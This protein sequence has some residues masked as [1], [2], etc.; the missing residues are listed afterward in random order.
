MALSQAQSEAGYATPAAMVLS[1]AIAITALA[2]LSRATSELQIARADLARTQV[3]Y[4]L[5]GAQLLA[6]VQVIRSERPGPYRWTVP[7]EIGMTEAT[8]FPEHEKL[9][10]A[11]AAAMPDAVFTAFGVAEPARLKALLRAA[12]DQRESPE[13]PDMDPALDWRRCGGTLVS[14]YGE[15]TAFRYQKPNVPGPGDRPSTWH[16][17]EVWRIAVTT[18]AGWRDE[19]IV[20]F[21]GDARDPVA[22]V[23]R[24]LSRIGG[25]WGRC[26]TI[27]AGLPLG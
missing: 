25:D 18:D 19:R 12:A 3:A 4:A 27:L 10:L 13:P 23:E 15:G 16:I 14:A 24:R 1:L 8:A 6:A 26:E 11:T 17:G 21:T 22:I 5:D 7:S 2:V 9:S 20:R